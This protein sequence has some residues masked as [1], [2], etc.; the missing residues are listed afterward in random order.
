MLR[1]LE[2]VRLQMRKILNIVQSMPEDALSP[3]RPIWLKSQPT[4]MLS[5]ATIPASDIHGSFPS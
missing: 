4:A 3:H 1:I 5:F 2:M